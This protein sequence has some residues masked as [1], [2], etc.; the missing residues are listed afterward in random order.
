MITELLDAAITE[1][2]INRYEISQVQLGKEPMQIFIE[3]SKKAMAIPI[4]A[5]IATITSYKGISIAPHPTRN[6]VMYSLN[7]KP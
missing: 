3:E 1:A 6:A 2:I 4:K 5:D 7:R